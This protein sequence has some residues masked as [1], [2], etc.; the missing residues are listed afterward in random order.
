MPSNIL[1][2]IV[3]IGVVATFACAFFAWRQIK[4]GPSKTSNTINQGNRNTQKGGAGKTENR[5]DRGDDN[6][7]QG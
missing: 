1:D 5:I 4:G 7:Q 2:F 3:I 6:S